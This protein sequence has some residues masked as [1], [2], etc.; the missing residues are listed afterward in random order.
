M[1]DSILTLDVSSISSIDDIKKS[2]DPVRDK[3]LSLKI[4]GVDDKA[5]FK[6]VH[7]ARMH[8]RKIRTS[9]EN[10]RKEL[11]AVALEYGRSVDA[12]AK[13]VAELIAPIEDHLNGEEMAIKREQDRI[14]AEEQQRQEKRT[15]DRINA[16]TSIGATV[17]MALVKNLS[18]GEFESLLAMER[19]AHSEREEARKKR[20]EE[21]AAE[22]ERIAKERAEIKQKQREIEAQI[23]AKREAREAEQKKR[24][25]EERNR[26]IEERKRI[27]EERER[28]RIEKEQ[29][30]VERIRIEAETA[31]AE[32]IEAE[33]NMPPATDEFKDSGPVLSGDT[34]PGMCHALCLDIASKVRIVSESCGNDHVIEM[35]FSLLTEA[36]DILDRSINS[37]PVD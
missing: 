16:L 35:V 18:D 28:L 15:E 31:E 11:K 25:E 36:S 26:I 22:R 29:L 21:E 33:K 14:K 8:C 23:Q 20:E 27:V 7:E 32:R 13:S 37:M 19:K 4:N 5:G 17:N 6:E 2:I 10:K 1:S 34:M 12:A 24:D 30:E 9:V 3:Y